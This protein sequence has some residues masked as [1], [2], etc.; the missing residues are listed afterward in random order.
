MKRNRVEN[1]SSDLSNQKTA[2]ILA[3]QNIFYLVHFKYV[4]VLKNV[5]DTWIK[6]LY[7]YNR[8]QM[9]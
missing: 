6:K 8:L 7:Y 3:K 1:E 4:H 2:K 5:D 9:T